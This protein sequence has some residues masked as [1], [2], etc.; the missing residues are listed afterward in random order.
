MPAAVTLKSR[1]P[2]IEV[3]L[4]RRVSQDIKDGGEA[5]LE[6]A[7]SRINSQTGELEGSGSVQ[8]GAAEVRVEYTAVY[9]KWIEFGR[10]NAPPF[11][12]LMPAAEEQ[13]PEILAAVE[14]S[15]QGL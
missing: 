2:E 5:I 10:K 6:A 15:L 12:F 1:F 13:A 9:A 8:G 4:A 11:P 14:R 7:N 3:A